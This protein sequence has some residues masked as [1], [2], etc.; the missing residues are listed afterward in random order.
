MNDEF[1]K[2]LKYESYFNSID[3]IV[4][5]PISN[6]S[7]FGR[8][9]YTPLGLPFVNYVLHKP[10]MHEIIH[11]SR[12]VT[13]PYINVEFRELDDVVSEFNKFNRDYRN[14]FG[15]LQDLV[16]E[17]FVGV[18]VVFELFSNNLDKILYI[19][20]NEGDSYYQTIYNENNLTRVDTLLEAIRDLSKE[21]I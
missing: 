18:P 13:T 7:I 11:N 15:V 16:I 4:Y 3:S 8:L 21:C 2:L 1:E 17:D 5:S 20:Y 6:V 19:W 12:L 10:D 9:Y 14:N